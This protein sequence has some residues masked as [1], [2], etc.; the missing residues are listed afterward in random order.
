MADLITS[1]DVEGRLGITVS[2]GGVIASITSAMAA[3][4][5][6]LGSLLNTDF[7]QGNKSDLFYLNPATA[8]ADDG[9]YLMRLSNGF[10]DLGEVF[11][12]IPG[13]TI[14]AAL[15]GSTEF[16]DYLLEVEKGFVRVPE[17]FAGSYFRVNYGYGF[18]A[19][20]SVPDWLKEAAIVETIRVLATQQ[21]SDGK[22]ELS[23]L[24]PELER[25]SRTILARRGRS[26]SS[27]IAPMG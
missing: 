8:V 19:P 18:D 6:Q 16:E 7:N 27:S 21:I 15:N 13:D 14:S 3:A 9:H 17:S 4:K 5:V 26:K 23:N 1:A 11:S 10:V 20:D 24:L 22:P 2:D 12:V 25:Q